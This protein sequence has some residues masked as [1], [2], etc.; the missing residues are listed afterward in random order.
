MKLKNPI[1]IGFGIHNH[2]TFSKACEY[3]NGAIVG[4]A[5]IKAIDESNN[6][7]KN[8][9]EFVQNILG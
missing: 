5:F 8:I 2:Q 9:C 4:S 3:A 6:L 1:V 7:K